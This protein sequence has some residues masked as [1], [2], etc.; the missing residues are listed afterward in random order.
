M[1]RD[2]QSPKVQL[3]RATPEDAEA[4]GRIFL[5]AFSGINN[6]H[7]F[8][9][10]I[11][12]VESAIGIL[13]MLFSHPGFYCVLAER[14]GQTLGSVCQDERSTIA[15]VGPLSIAPDARIEELDAFLP[16]R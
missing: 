13:A 9:P 16:C 3:R 14:D 4:C 8:A 7:G 12:T 5:E 11:P 2:V 1:P 10:E 15:G 6:Q